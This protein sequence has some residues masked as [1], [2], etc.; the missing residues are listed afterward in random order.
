MLKEITKEKENVFG[1]FR[2]FGTILNKIVEDRSTTEIVKGYPCPI[3]DV[4]SMY[5]KKAIINFKLSWIDYEYI[6]DDVLDFYCSLYRKK[7]KIYLEDG[8]ERK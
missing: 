1:T 5:S 6:I 3:E 7:L 2:F 8:K 4:K